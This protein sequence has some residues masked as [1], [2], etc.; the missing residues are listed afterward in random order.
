[1]PASHASGASPGLTRGLRPVRRGGL[2]HLREREAARPLARGHGTAGLID[3]DS[4]RRD[5]TYRTI[6]DVVPF[7]L[8]E[9]PPTHA[10]QVLKESG[11]ASASMTVCF[12][13]V[14]ASGVGS[15]RSPRS[16]R[17]SGWSP[18]TGGSTCSSSVS[19][20]PAPTGALV[21]PTSAGDRLRPPTG[22]EGRCVHFNYGWVPYEE[23]QSYLREADLDLAHH[24]HL[25]T[26]F[27]FRTRVLDYIW[28]GL[29]MVLTRGDSMGELVERA[30]LG[31]TVAPEDD[32]GFA[33]ACAA[34]LDD[35][36]AACENRR[37]CGRRPVVSLGAG[38]EPAG[39]LLPEPPQ[40]AGTAP[41]PARGLD[42]HLRS[43]P[44]ILAQ[45]VTTFGP[46]EAARR[47]VRHLA[48]AP[49]RAKA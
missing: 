40:P 21:D 8:S 30:G 23:R 38:G 34:L 14:E 9:R 36:R 26:R 15:T 22:L 7:G 35:R 32:E 31:A 3:L 6:V 33:S 5:R 1:M 39:R 41:A 18:R 44:G 19:S 2:R 27:S 47:V 46:A 45:L 48:R 11:R 28:A 29:P 25:E 17:S 24:D 37:A 4:Y 13:G 12:C 42:G 10:Q 49:P 43:V 20:A 16:R